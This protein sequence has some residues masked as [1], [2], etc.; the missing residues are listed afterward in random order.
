[1]IMRERWG[2]IFRPYDLE[3]DDMSATALDI[4]QDVK[5]RVEIVVHIDESLDSAQRSR[6]AMLLENSEGIGNCVFCEKRFHLMLVN[7]DR[8]LTTSQEILGRIRKHH[9]SAKLI[10]PV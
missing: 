3:G 10:G 9:P 5:H 2:S 1:M 4:N 7:Y 6:L 8:K